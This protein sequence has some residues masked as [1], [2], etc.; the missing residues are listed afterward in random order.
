MLDP[1]VIEPS[2]YQAIA[3]LFSSVPMHFDAAAFDPT[4]RDHWMQAA[5]VVV[6][7]DPTRKQNTQRHRVLITLNCWQRI[8]TEMYAGL[9]LADTVAA[10]LDHGRVTL[11]DYTNVAEPVVG[12]LLLGEVNRRDLSDELAADLRTDW[13]HVRVWAWGW[14]QET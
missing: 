10:G 8:T 13:Q 1:L 12:T 3:T 2:T 5:V 14:A 11:R 4:G 7:E 9:D 6:R